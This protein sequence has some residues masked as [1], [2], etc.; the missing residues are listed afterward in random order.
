MAK[1]KPT[2]ELVTVPNFTFN[3]GDPFSGDGSLSVER[4]I[5]VRFYN[6]SIE[7]VQQGNYPQQ[8]EKILIST[9]YLKELFNEISA[10]LPESKKRWE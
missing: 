9:E 4:P 3:Q 2:T 6:G 1:R 7:L 5:E 8:P 10:H